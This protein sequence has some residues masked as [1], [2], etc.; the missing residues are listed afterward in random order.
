[1]NHLL[2]YC[3]HF[4][5]KTFDTLDPRTEEAITRVS[6]AQKEDVDLAVKAARAAFDHG[7]WP[8]MSG[9][10]RNYLIFF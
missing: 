7:P 6:E 3:V 8:R 4:A 2:I 1:L 9:S 10:V 5:G